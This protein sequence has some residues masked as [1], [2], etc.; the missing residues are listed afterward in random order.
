MQLS[1]CFLILSLA[2]TGTFGASHN[3]VEERQI[4]GLIYVR[5]YAEPNCQGDFV[6]DGAYFDSGEDVCQFPTF[7]VGYRS[8]N[9]V[10]NDAIRPCELNNNQGGVLEFLSILTKS[11]T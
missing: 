10:T 2:A 11:I 8:W 1:T 4:P 7:V 3:A 6:E 9:V 5:S